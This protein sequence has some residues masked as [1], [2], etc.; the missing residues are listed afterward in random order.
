MS[1][2][3]A[4]AL[5][6]GLLLGAG[7]GALLAWLVR[8]RALTR[9]LVRASE[10]DGANALL[11]ADNAA[12]RRQQGDTRALDDL[13]QPVRDSLESLRQAADRSSRDRTEAE[14]TLTTQIAA[15]QERY[16]SLETATKQLAS[17]LARGQSRG[18]WGEMQLEGLLSHSGLVEGV[19]YRRQD[20]RASADGAGRPDVVVVM[21][22]GGEI[23]V[24]AKFPFDAYWQGIGTDEPA[25]RDALMRKHADDVLSRAKELSG[26]R[27]SDVAASPDFVVMFLPLESLLSAALEA[28]G[29]LLER[30]FTLRVILATPTTMLALLRT[31]GFG[32]QRQLMADNAEEIKRA[33]AEMLAR[34]GTLAEHLNGM[35][36]GLDQAVRGYNAFVGSFD[37]QAMRQARRLNDL[38]VA[39][40]R[41]LEAPGEIDVALRQSDPAALRG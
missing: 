34:L 24:D 38:G 1:S 37:S 14:A 15:V 35:R 27:Y 41:P 33:G 31:I 30:T 12:L 18:Q 3:A 11:S 39:T 13:I 28:D 17:A 25:T 32:Y 22:G 8:G 19:H 21:P 26:K 9:A 40:S 4:A 7:L 36:R 16:Q 20:T 23:L 29:L 6:V 5:A 10:L 2:S